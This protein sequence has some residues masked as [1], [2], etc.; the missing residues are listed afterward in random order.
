M[1]ISGV[2]QS[3]TG[4]YSEGEAQVWLTFSLPSRSQITGV[5]KT[6]IDHIPLSIGSVRPTQGKV[7][8]VSQV[9]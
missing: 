3:S 6:M 9:C 8:A 4:A 2:R 1:R 5:F 7:L